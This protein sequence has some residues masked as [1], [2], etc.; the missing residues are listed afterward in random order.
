MSDAAFT[1]L[2]TERL[3][4]RRFTDAD[5][6]TLA[7]YRSE[8]D[9]ARYQ[10]WEA[11]FGVDRAREFIAT[12]ARTHPDTPGEWFQLAIDAH[13]RHI[14][15]VALFVD[16]D[17]P[18]LA[19]IGFTLAPQAQGHGY[20]S[21]AVTA[22]LD[23]LFVARGKHRVSAD[24]DARNARSAALLER[25]GMRREAHHLANGWWKGEWTD[26]YVY[27]VL[28]TEWAQRRT[29]GAPAQSTPSAVGGS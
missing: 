23:Y 29:V 5:A 11:P 8:P 1:E 10:G 21:E 17:E 24:C 4:L 3:V 12:L 16:G 2:R 13:G 15:D 18:R 20:A 19:R 7:A 22:V 25:I 26:E 28:A 9:V 6:E 27:A 14:G